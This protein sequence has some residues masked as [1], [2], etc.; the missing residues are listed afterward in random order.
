MTDSTSRNSAALLRARQEVKD[1]NWPTAFSILSEA[2]QRRE[3]C[4]EGLLLLGE[5]ARW[6]GR[7]DAIADPIERAHQEYVASGNRQGAFHSALQLSQTNEDAGRQ[8]LAAAWW[9]RA[10]ELIAGVPEG[11]EHAWH[12]WV[13]N[14]NCG[15]QGKLDEQ[16]RHAHHALELARRFGD[17]NVE[18]LALIDLSH[19]ATNRGE[20][21]ATLEFVKRATSMAL[22]GEIDIFATGM[23]FCNAI[24]ACRCRGEWQRAQEWT[25]SAT[26]WVTRQQVEYFPG[27]CRVHRSEVLRIRGDLAAAER[28]SEAATRQ[29]AQSMPAYA[30]FPWSELG[31]VRRRRGNFEGAMDAFQHAISLGWDPQPGLSLLLLLQGEATAAHRSIERS[32]L[33]PRPT[34]MCEDR[35]NLLAARAAIAVAVDERSIAE[36]A[37]AELEDMA[38]RNDTLWDKATAASGRGLL[39]LTA[40]ESRKA[41]E[42]LTTARRRWVELNTPYELA[43][44]CVLLGRALTATGEV[45]EAKLALAAAR[46]GFERIGAEF[47]R[48]RTQAL[49]DESQTSPPQSPHHPVSAP[50]Q[51]AKLKREGEYWSIVFAGRSLQL[52]SSRGVEHL[53]KLLKQPGADCWAI[54]LAGSGGI[55][56]RGDAGEMLDDTARNAYRERA[57]ELQQELSEIDAAADPWRVEQ[58][59]TELDTIARALAAAVGI[60]GRPR[61]AGSAVER[62][63]QSVTKSIRGTIR[64]IAESNPE[65]GQ[66]LTAT[67]RTGTACRFEATLREPVRWDVQD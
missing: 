4:A 38:Q 15:A 51:S 50:V 36:A 28:E 12:A 47:D 34:M 14:R 30:T 21:D 55:P 2:D 33:D 35:A 17:R 62:A 58:L 8:A 66:Y 41:V 10:D 40:G 54:D 19:V 20:N 27:M 16:E 64:R 57:T 22:G 3:L 61:R 49:L 52:R 13:Q 25:E 7:N 18:A 11:P 31:E 65:L 1:R 37:V 6:T 9:E 44:A 24:W 63:R 56:D 39:H 60:G 43:H 67:I 32:F 59:R 46:D 26:R 53:A 5:A 45:T 29:V 42:H 23:V 48:D